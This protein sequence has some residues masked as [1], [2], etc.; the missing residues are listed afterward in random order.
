MDLTG[1][2][3]SSS[4]SPT[5]RLNWLI[6]IVANGYTLYNMDR[7]CILSLE[8]T[9]A[10]Y[11][12]TIRREKYKK[13]KKD[14]DRMRTDGKYRIYRSVEKWTCEWRCECHSVAALLVGQCTEAVL[15]S[16]W[17][18]WKMKKITELENTAYHRFIQLIC[19]IQCHPCQHKQICHAHW[20]VERE[21]WVS[22]LSH[23]AAHTN[24][25]TQSGIGCL[26]CYGNGEL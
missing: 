6:L 2:A 12:T 20:D 9:I 22:V 21:N 17:K 4:N 3:R 13:K 1:K 14:L 23:T 26:C 8:R 11:S 10:L 18:V 25:D 7:N 16:R 24:R 15:Q 19:F 5:R